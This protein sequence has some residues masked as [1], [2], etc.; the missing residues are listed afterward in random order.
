MVK[1]TY[2]AWGNTVTEVLDCNANAIAELNPFRY[3]GY[4]YDIETELYFLKSRYYDPELGRFMTVD[5]VS[6]LDP[7]T[8]NGL[9]LYAYCGNNPVMCADPNGTF[10]ITFGGLL[11][12]IAIGAVISAAISVASVKDKECSI[13]DKIIKVSTD[14]LLGGML[15]ASLALGG[16]IAAGGTLFGLSTAGSLLAGI[17]ISLA[18][19]AVLG[20]ASSMISQK[21][22]KGTIDPRR[23]VSD[24]AVASVKGLVSFLGGS[25]TGGSGL[26]PQATE[27]GT[28]E[29]VAKLGLHLV[30]KTLGCLIVDTLYYGTKG[31]PIPW[32]EFLSKLLN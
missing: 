8:I 24:S 30:Y 1:Y 25:I 14:A 29:F 3:R 21:I 4:Y 19:T 10:A 11:L 22:D 18:G 15:G 6:Y 9:N 12:S 17:G 26:W 13:E 7:D 32:A 5:D 28:V 31:E 16:L 2:D 20:G 27:L 23:V